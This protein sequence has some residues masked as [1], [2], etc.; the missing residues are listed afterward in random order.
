MR[1]MR[2]LT[3]PNVGGPTMQAVALWHE[4]RALG[5]KTVL[6]V[7]TCL[8]GEASVD[9]EARGI[10]QLRVDDVDR[11]SEG[12]V[13]VEHLGNRRS[14]FAQRRA[15]AQLAMLMRRHCPDVVH[16]HTSAAGLAGRRAAWACG[17]ER[18]VHTFHGIVLRDYFGPLVSWALLRIEARL[19]RRTAALVAVSA[20]CRDELAELGV[21]DASRIRV[22]PPAVPLPTFLPR[23]EARRR[24]S[25][26]QDAFVVGAYGR[27]VPIKRLDLFLDVLAAMP[28]ATGRVFGD[29]PLRDRLTRRAPAN[30]AFLPADP[31]A[32][33]CMSAFDA[34]L[35]P[36]RREGCP[37]VAIE[38]FAAGVPVVG[39]DVPGVRD[40]LATWGDGILVPER[41]GAAGLAGALDRLRRDPACGRELAARAKE[42]LFRFEPRAVAAELLD[43]YRS[44]PRGSARA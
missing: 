8:R 5:V 6:A 7:G 30:C 33:A 19:A 41:E 39:F 16:T 31:D 44:L 14:P 24:L 29:G 20:S 9:L 27:L 4:H 43:L 3:R 1:V 26:P 36:S 34:L 21:A 40:V 32:R 28:E 42:V 38:A 22:V 23:A 15:T 11:D 35:L 13:V 37:L 12:F 18:T 2:V 17:I 10:P 25:L